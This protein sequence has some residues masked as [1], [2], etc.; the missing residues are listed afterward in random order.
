LLFP[1][2]GFRFT[3]LLVLLREPRREGVVHNH[4]AHHLFHEVLHEVHKKENWKQQDR[5][6]LHCIYDHTFCAHVNPPQ[7]NFVEN[8]QAAKM[9]SPLPPVGS[10]MAA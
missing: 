10:E 4:A 7:E 2:R 5:L 8:K 6:F 1:V 3:L 9:I